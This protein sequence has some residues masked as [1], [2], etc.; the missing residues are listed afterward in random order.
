[1]PKSELRLFLFKKC[2][3]TI[4]ADYRAELW[5]SKLVQIFCDTSVLSADLIYCFWKRRLR[6]LVVASVTFNMMDEDDYLRKEVSCSNTK[7]RYESFYYLIILLFRDFEDLHKSLD[8]LFIC[9]YELMNKSQQIVL[10]TRFLL[11]LELY[12]IS[13]ITLHDVCAVHWGYQ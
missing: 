4:L 13:G 2:D 8:P 3:L 7:R 12:R 11:K 6:V 9:L 10:Q 5:F 1:M